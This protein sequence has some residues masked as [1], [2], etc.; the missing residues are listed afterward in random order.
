MFGNRQ[1]LG[2]IARNTAQL[3]MTASLGKVLKSEIT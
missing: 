3:N 1:G 2:L